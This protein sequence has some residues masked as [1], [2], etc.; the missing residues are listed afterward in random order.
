MTTYEYSNYSDQS[1]NPNI[2]I[3]LYVCI[4][5]VETTRNLETK[6]KKLYL[7]GLEYKL[8]AYIVIT[9]F[10]E[11]GSYRTGILLVELLIFFLNNI[12][13]CRQR[14]SLILLL[15]SKIPYGICT[16]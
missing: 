8:F 5:Q 2:M 12:L 3:N 7:N 14:E 6:V 10:W 15:R 4:Q 1:A 13:T 16:A 11:C 9:L